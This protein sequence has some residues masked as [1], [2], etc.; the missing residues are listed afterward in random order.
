MLGMHTLPADE[1]DPAEKC[2]YASDQSVQW[3]APEQRFMTA[4]V[5]Q[6]KPLHEAHSQE[7]L[8]AE[9]TN[10]AQA[11]HG[12]TGKGCRCNPGSMEKAKLIRRPEC[13]AGC[14]G[15]SQYVA[16]GIPRERTHRDTLVFTRRGYIA[17]GQ[18]RM[19]P[20][21]IDAQNQKSETLELVPP[22]FGFVVSGMLLP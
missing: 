17:Y 3:T 5:K 19:G 1:R 12:Q 10:A 20:T 8:T 21:F 15:W 6:N 4:F 13:D 2:R 16:P 11:G 22:K 9:P 14:R 7:K 18:D